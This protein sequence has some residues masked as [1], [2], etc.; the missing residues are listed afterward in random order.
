[1]ITATGIGSGLDIG[2]L[3]SQLVSAERAGSDL[4]LSRESARINVELSGFAA[5]KSSLATFQSSLSGL[6]NL[7]T[8][9]QKKA[10]SSDTAA[11][12]V[13]ANSTAIASKYAVE[14]SQLADSHALASNA[15]ADTDVTTLGTGTI[16]FRFGT[17][18]YVP[19]TDT[20]NS[21][22]LNPDSSTATITI[23][24]TNNTLEGIMTAINDADIG[25]SASIV[26]DGSG[27]R[28]LLSSG[29][30]GEENSLE[31]AVSDNDG[32]NTD[33]AG[34]SIFTFNAGSTNLGQTRAANDALFT[35]NGLDVASAENTV[36]TAIPGATLT[37]N[38][39]TTGVVNIDISEDT[40]KIVGAVNTFISG[41]NSFRAT[42]KKLTAY[43]PA[44]NTAGTFQGDFTVRSIVSQVD[45][46][47]R[48]SIAGL[49]GSF[50]N[51]AELGLKTDVSSGGLILD[52]DKF[53]QVLA[54]NKQDVI[55]I[56][57]AL[58]IP[59]DQDVL[60]QGAGSATEVGN[61]SVN[62]TQLAAAGSLAG[63]GVLPDFGG[64]GTVTIDADNDG[65]TLEVDGVDAGPLVLT[66][67][68]YSSGQ[69]LADEF[70]TQINGSPALK[71]VGKTV[72]V[73]Y[74]NVG[75]KLVITSNT[76]GNSSTVNMLAVDT[77][78]LAALGFDV[79]S[80]TAGVD[81]AGTIGGEA[82]TGAGRIL[83]SDAGTLPDGMKLMIN[84]DTTGSRGSVAFT[85][86][87]ANQIQ[88]Y[89][90]K[91]LDADEG[92]IESRIN[93][94]DTRKTTL[95][96]KRQTLE[97]KWAAV[98]ERYLRQ[99]NALDALMASLQSTSSYLQTQ[100]ASL[101]KPNSIKG[102]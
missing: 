38:K 21:F 59:D 63:T 57:T 51:M 102:Q 48:N 52:A 43:D 24:G 60:Y 23:D 84:G 55:S 31:I 34:L 65:F 80:G 10:T 90:E 40:Q 72:A 3:V 1:M 64:G 16:T 86:G 26:N 39:V 27:F 78:T 98:E 82:A 2:G 8:Y 101:P 36:S 53:N 66:A 99:F 44:T 94:L 58:G 42:I 11:I 12:S 45:N 95:E 32:N 67:G 25:V 83:I 61:Y 100:L 29:R 15:A 97:T 7:S 70:Q 22:T 6:D 89:L 75:N 35:I 54:S 41:Y 49:G 88:L 77:S 30:T 85:R 76:E 56:F 93:N 14:V 47:M 73:T 96:S 92:T 19:G 71:L 4:Q 50:T 87:L 74:D 79:A 20:Y 69:A 37:F 46:M 9:D 91:L 5:L 28:L 68:V 17:T 18:D 81:V 13:T 62:I 33:N